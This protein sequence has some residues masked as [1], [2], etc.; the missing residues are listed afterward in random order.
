MFSFILKRILVLIPV[1]F[2]LTLSTFALIR[3]VPGDTVE[4]MMGQR[5]VDP[6]MHAQAMHRLGLDKP[7]Y[8]QYWDYLVKLAHGD[9]GQSFRDQIDVGADF[10]AHF[11]PTLEL[12]LVAMTL[13]SVIGVA[14]G[15]IAALNRGR[16]LDYSLMVGALA[17]YSMPIYL[18]G[19][20]LTG[21]FAHFLGWLPISGVI[22]TIEYLDVA[23]KHGS[24][25]LG[26]LASDEDGALWD[27]L[28]HFIL[29]SIAL[30]T[31]PLATIARMTRS[32][33]LEVLGEDYVRTARAKG[34]SPTRVILVHVLRNALITVVTV[35]GLQMGTLLAGAILTETIFSWPGVG[36]WLLDGFHNRDYPVVQNGI[37]LVAG[38]LMLVSLLVDVLYGLI[39][40]RIRHL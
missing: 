4:V 31:I 36:N 24:W 26:A 40:P 2:G 11:I 15:I 17:G 6:E 23:P 20:I 14:L 29:P 7:L 1:F 27:V 18:L 32:A 30:A 13:A 5:A 9:F 22:N 25:L 10:F 3:M 33:M 19:P 12:A 39:N 35:I 37:L 21:I 38:A 16:W 34:L 8:A 28:K